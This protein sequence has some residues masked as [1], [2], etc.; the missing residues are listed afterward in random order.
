VENGGPHFHFTRFEG[1]PISSLRTF[2]NV[3]DFL[4]DYIF[5]IMITQ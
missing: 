3:R 4:Y 2:T 1:A 5:I